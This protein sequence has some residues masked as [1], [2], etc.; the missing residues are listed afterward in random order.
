MIRVVPFA[1]ERS[2]DDQPQLTLVR[3][4]RLQ[5]RVHRQELEGVGCPR[6]R[7]RATGSGF[8]RITPG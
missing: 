7:Y 2:I 4:L 1:D 6:R 3:L 8:S 5:A